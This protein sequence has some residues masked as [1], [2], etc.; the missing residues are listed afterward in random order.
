MG[1]KDPRGLL[2]GYLFIFMTYFFS[3]EFYTPF[4]LCLFVL[5][6]L[7]VF[8][9]E[10]NRLFVWVSIAFFL[11]NIISKYADKYIESYP[12]SPFTLVIFG[13]LLLIIPIL[14][15][16]YVMKQFKRKIQPIFGNP[17]FHESLWA[18]TSC[19]LSM[20]ILFRLIWITLT[21]WIILILLIYRKDLNGE[22][23]F[24]ILLFS[25]L[26]ALLEEILWRRIVLQQLTS[27]MNKRRGIIV[28]SIAF[29]LNTTMFGYSPH[30]YF[31]YI[32]LGLVLGVLTVKTKSILPSVFIHFL[33]TILLLISG[34]FVIPI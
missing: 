14:L 33:V 23:I 15:M 4:F 10:N 27:M 16:G 28:T 30:I 18:V 6:L 11:G 13:Q 12:L 20:K 24:F 19:R 31:I 17:V 7:V 26:H 34:S 5:L 3:R 21:I 25:L 22:N 1:L 2:S 9:Q 32:G 8:L 29:G